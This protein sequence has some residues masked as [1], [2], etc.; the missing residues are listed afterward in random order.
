MKKFV[1]LLSFLF[2]LFLFS[3]SVS[4]FSVFYDFSSYSED[5]LLSL[6]FVP[7]SEFKFAFPSRLGDCMLVRNYDSYPSFSFPSF[8]SFSPLDN[9]N[10]SFSFT[11]S[12]SS[13]LLI[14]FSSF[15]DFSDIIYS[16][17]LSPSHSLLLSWRTSSSSFIF[18]SFDFRYGYVYF[19]V[20]SLDSKSESFYISSFYLSD[21]LDDVGLQETSSFSDL[22]YIVD[23]LKS[24]FFGGS[25]TDPDTGQTFS[26][27]QDGTGGIMNFVIYSS[28]S[29]NFSLWHLFVAASIIGLGISF[30][31]RLAGNFGRAPDNLAKKLHDDDE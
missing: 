25:V 15:S 14:E 30:V 17:R 31:I 19:R 16:Y 8:S 5:D 22:Q 12:S 6:G 24:F 7:D 18:N 9:S 21:S 20:R 10:L 1:F 27:G 13:D 29:T 26:F 3:I 23:L 11:Y 28:G 4:A 2:S